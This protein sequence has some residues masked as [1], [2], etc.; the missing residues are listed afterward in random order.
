MPLP[1][2]V[3][4]RPSHPQVAALVE[5]SVSKT[6]NV[7]MGLAKALKAALY[8][9]VDKPQRK[10]VDTFVEALLALKTRE[11]ERTPHDGDYAHPFAVLDAFQRLQQLPQPLLASLQDD[12]THAYLASTD[13]R[14]WAVL[15]SRQLSSPHLV[16]LAHRV[17][18]QPDPTTC[19][20]RFAI[21]AQNLATL[22][23]WLVP[24]FKNPPSLIAFHETFKGASPLVT[25]LC[26]SAACAWLRVWLDAASGVSGQAALCA[27]LVS[28]WPAV[29]GPILAHTPIDV[30]LALFDTPTLP[31]AVHQAVERHLDTTPDLG[32][33]RAFLE[34]L[35]AHT[36]E[37]STGTGPEPAWAQRLQKYRPDIFR[38]F[39]LANQSA[40][41]LTHPQWVYMLFN[42]LDS[43]PLPARAL[44]D[45]GLLNYALQHLVLKTPQ[46]TRLTT[47]DAYAYVGQHHGHTSDVWH[48]LLA[49]QATL[50]Q[51]WDDAMDNA[52]AIIDD[53]EAKAHAFDHIARYATQ[54]QAWP[55]VEAA[56]LSISPD[57][58]WRDDSL[59][60]LSEAMLAQNPHLA[61]TLAEAIAS[62][63]TRTTTRTQALLAANPCDLTLIVCQAHQPPVYVPANRA[64]LMKISPYFEAMITGNFREA[65]QNTIA[66]LDQNP[67][68]IAALVAFSRTG[69]LPASTPETALALLFLADFAQVPA[70]QQHATDFLLAQADDD[71]CA[72]LAA[73]YP[74]PTQ[75]PTVLLPL[76]EGWVKSAVLNKNLDRFVT[77]RPYLSDPAQ[78]NLATQ[79][80][81]NNFNVPWTA[82]EAKDYQ[83]AVK[84]ALYISDC[85]LQD[86]WGRKIVEPALR[87]K[88]YQAATYAARCIS[89]PTLEN[90]L[91]ESIAQAALEDRHYQAAVDAAR[92]IP[93]PTL[94]DQW[95]RKIVEP[96][97]KAEHYQVAVEAAL[98]I[99][100]LQSRDEWGRKI[101]KT[102]FEAREYYAAASATLCISDLQLR[103]QLCRKIVET[104]FGAKDYQTA[105]YF[106][107]Y[108]SDL[109]LREQ[110]YESTARAVLEAK[111]YP[112]AV[113]AARCI[114]DPTLQKRLLE[115]I[116]K[117]AL[118]DRHYQ[119]AI[120]TARFISDLT[121][122]NRCLESI[123]RAALEAEQ[124]QV[125]VKAACCIT[126]DLRLEERLCREIVE[127]AL[128]ARAYQAAASAARHISDTRLQNGRLE[129]IAKAALEG[130]AHQA[131]LDAARCI[132]DPT[133]ENRLLESI[134]KAALE[135][136]QYQLA[137]DTA[138]YISDTTLRDQRSRKIVEPALRA[139]EY[140]VA[141]YAARCISDPT[142][143]NRL[144]ERI[145][146]AALEDRHYQAAADTARYIS[147]TTVRE[148][149]LQKS[150]WGA[151]FGGNDRE[152]L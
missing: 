74:D 58:S 53:A 107:R 56:A 90:R 119:V 10:R 41:F 143:Q 67:E 78:A 16:A 47:D 49:T 131:A 35:L 14:C 99:S 144:L 121:L 89:D 102:A 100:D 129:S 40:D 108:I 72:T 46:L 118:E 151:R 128:G 146:Q 1:P 126:S 43:L 103:E 18:T 65:T 88:A 113:D 137:I 73:D 122:R 75:L 31:E 135:A 130:E 142:L 87:T 30:W 26:E 24:H 138:R 123:S 12:L 28:A 21:H 9:Q 11:K 17:L 29:I 55:T 117:A 152:G 147:D 71:F 97:F 82:F 124:Y 62:P 127:P 116:A 57:C 93:D 83:A 134:A 115:S 59:K 52:C 6:P 15:F 42:L 33:N 25:P 141:T 70:L 101:V 84:T 125:A 7:R 111:D 45:A 22:V 104:A 95:G 34:W 27:R 139:K 105:V 94:R 120:D 61:I 79:P 60:S 54:A 81:W 13:S 8:A 133:L 77:L 39:D 63:T 69:E 150:S 4:H 145:A 110:L 2:H 51:R 50:D 19:L 23:P 114:S 86:Q 96:A 3:A 66:L 32:Q 132:S 85:Q 112:A 5:A 136:E 37:V 98:R 48:R 109:P 44:T 92:R 76:I 140:Q 106:A 149:I 64:A 38:E 20:T 36:K 91:L 80:N 148:Q 68:A